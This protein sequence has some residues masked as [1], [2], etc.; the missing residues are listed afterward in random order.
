MEGSDVVSARWVQTSEV[1]G[2]ASLRLFVLANTA[3]L[4]VTAPGQ[5]E[6][7]TLGSGTGAKQ[8]WRRKVAIGAAALVAGT[9]VSQLYFRRAPTAPT[10]E[11]PAV[12]LS[13]VPP[14]DVTLAPGVNQ[15]V[16]VVSP[17][18]RRVAFSASR[19]GEPVRIWVRSLESL[20]ARPLAGTDN[21]RGPFWSPD[22]RSLAFFAEG[23]LKTID[24][25]GGPVQ[26]VCRL[27]NAAASPGASWS[28]TNTI[29]LARRTGG[30]MKVAAS[31]GEPTLTTVVDTTNGD[32][33]HVFPTFLPDGRQFLYLSRPS[34]TLWL[35]TLD[36]SEAT[37]L[38]SS[39]SQ[40]FYADGHLLFAR[41]GVLLAQR[42]DVS[43][44]TLAGDPTAIAERLAVD[45]ILGAPAFSSSETGVLVYRTGAGSSQ[46]Q[47]TW[48]DRSGKE[49]GKIGPVGR[50]RNPVLSGD[51]TR[52]ALEASDTENRT[53][54][55]W[56]LELPH[57]AP[58]RFTVDRGNDILPVWSPDDSRIAFGS[59]RQGGIYNLYEKMS[60]G[61]AGEKLLLAS[62]G[63]NLTGPADWS[64]DGRFLL[65]RDL[66]PKTSVVNTGILPLSGDRAISDLFPP[67]NFFQTG[68]QISPDGRWVAY[69]S[70]E[71]GRMEVYVARF[72][73][74]SGSRPISTGGAVYARWRG[75]SQELFY[76]AADGRIM[77]VPISGTTTLEVA[78]P[79]PLFNVRLL[80]GPATVTG[81][82]AQY[83][84]TADGK[85]FLLNLPVDETPDFPPITVVLNWTAGLRK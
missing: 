7:A 38:F 35:G 19:P 69:L 64:P 46:T 8:S 73:N 42:Y 5:E 77:A 10:T 68:P 34:N 3:S 79:V 80:G 56:I 9:A 78:T 13:L 16:P 2:Q 15:L 74:P 37:R 32:A 48:V 82:R 23:T 85:R 44:P 57:G 47:L 55:L 45:P 52:I 67:S 83:D 25:A 11:Q 28:R 21:A 58:S 66:S 18:G 24:A 60:S 65:F 76:Y 29:L 14:A 36:S 84:V 43:R 22:S 31:G 70:N 6:A 17:D 75:D 4:T 72:P 51:G 20:D 81:F 27:P 49:I 63:D 41:Q 71:T 53:Q 33:S 59:D 50:Y 12:R 62:T 26:M 30:L 39:D 54:D 40:A 1:A 61:S